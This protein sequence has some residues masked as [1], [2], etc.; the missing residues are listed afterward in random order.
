MEYIKV[1]IDPFSHELRRRCDHLHGSSSCLRPK[2][3]LAAEF[4]TSR[5]ASWS[6]ENPKIPEMELE[7][8][9]D[10]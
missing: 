4:G 10:P 6:N 7:D 2:L 8:F 5:K 1:K 9:T 3:A